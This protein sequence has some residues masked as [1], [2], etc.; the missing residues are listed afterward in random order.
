MRQILP[1]QERN[2]KTTNGVFFCIVDGKATDIGIVDELLENDQEITRQLIA[3]G[4]IRGFCC[5][6]CG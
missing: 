6:G 5:G 2:N 4:V 1:M 3:A